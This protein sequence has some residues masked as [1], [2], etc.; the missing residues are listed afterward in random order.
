MASRELVVL[1]TASQAPTRERNHNG[2][3]LRWDGYGILFD[4]GEGTQRQMVVAKVPSSAIDRICITHLHGDHCL[5]L[6]GILSR[7]SLD[8]RS[9]QVQVMVPGPSESDAKALLDV[10]PGRRTVDPILVPCSEGLVFEGPGFRLS[11]G[12][13]DHGIPTLGWRLD[14]PPGRTLDKEAL[15]RA[16]ISGPAVRELIEHGS[17]TTEKGTYYLEDVSY[18]RPGQSFA[19]VMDTRPCEAAVQ[20][21]EGVDM[22][23]CESTFL[24]LDE[25]LAERYGHLTARQ[26]GLLAKQAEVGLLV[27]THFSQ[28]YS[29]AAAFAAEAAEIF[30]RV[31]IARDFD[32]ITFSSRRAVPKV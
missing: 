5:G 3:L 13:L 1:G 15:E 24:S 32:V 29:D 16:G 11:A 18:P 14:E 30:P 31:V 21:A 4:P 25:K 27:L 23:L 9:G 28:R 19:L 8:G 7:M 12:W 6:P 10:V 17:L 2:Y 26:A 20:L 22:L